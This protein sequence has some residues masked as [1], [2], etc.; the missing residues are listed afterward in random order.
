METGL[1]GQSCYLRAE[2]QR[3]LGNPVQ[4]SNW[5]KIT[6]I[7][8]LAEISQHLQLAALVPQI[9][10]TL[11]RCIGAHTIENLGVARVVLVGRSCKGKFLKASSSAGKLIRKD[12]ATL[13]N[14]S[15]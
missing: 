8:C 2:I 13:L 7:N 3:Y 4:M 14:W 15:A 11:L 12:S 9:K 10:E 5:T 1:V 6:N